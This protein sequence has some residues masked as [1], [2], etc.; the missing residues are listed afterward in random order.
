MSTIV[1]CIIDKVFKLRD[2]NILENETTL[3]NFRKFTETLFQNYCIEYEFLDDESI[4]IEF[5]CA[6]IVYLALHLD[7]YSSHV[8]LFILPYHSI[9]RIVPKTWYTDKLLEY[10]RN[11]LKLC[12]YNP[13][14]YCLKYL[15]DSTIKVESPLYHR[16][17]LENKPESFKVVKI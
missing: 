12:N 7:E 1:D 9:H 11:A 16:E 2:L 14:R 13:V 3:D 15:N 17:E 6:R 10:E 8:D 5:A 4:Y